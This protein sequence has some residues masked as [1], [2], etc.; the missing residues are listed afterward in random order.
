[1]QPSSLSD[2]KVLQLSDLPDTVWRAVFEGKA[3]LFLGAGFS[4]KTSSVTGEIL[5]TATDLAIKLG[6][7]A[8][9]SKDA[10]KR[11]DLKKIGTHVAKRH[12]DEMLE[13]LL[14]T[15][16]VYETGQVQ[17]EIVNQ[18]WQR[19]YTTNYDNV[20]EMA[21]AEEQK[22]IIPIVFSDDMTQ[23]K[24][25]LCIHIN[26]SVKNLNAATLQS[27]FK[28]ITKSYLDEK[29]YQSPWYPFMMEDFRVAS[30]IIVIGYSMN[31][32]DHIINRLF[33]ALGMRE[34]LLF[35]QPAGLDAVDIDDFTNYGDLV[36]C[37]VEGFS[38]FLKERKETYQPPV[39]VHRREDFICFDHSYREVS[40]QASLSY[41]DYVHFYFHGK[42]KPAFFQKR[43]TGEYEALASRHQLAEVLRN[44][45]R[46][47]IF[48]LTASLG[49][50]KTIF[51]EMLRHE[52]MET[53][54]HV[55]FF[56]AKHDGVEDEV[57]EIC[58]AYAKKSCFVVMDDVY[59]NLD[60]LEMFK[61]YDT[62][63]I[64]FVLT[65]RTALASRV[66]DGV[67][68][69]LEST[70]QI[71]TISLQ[72]LSANECYEMAA[73]LQSQNL[74]S[75]RYEMTHWT[76]GKLA[77]YFKTK[78][79][80]SIEQILLDVFE[81]SV[82]KEHME[83]LVRGSAEEDPDFRDLLIGL[84][85]ASVWDLG[86]D[87]TMIFVL[88]KFERTQAFGEKEQEVLS[89]LFV[90]QNMDAY[91]P[92]SSIFAKAVLFKIFRPQEIMQTM[93]RV[94]RELHVFGHTDATCESAMKAILSHGSYK[95]LISSAEGRVAVNQFYDSLRELSWYQENPFYW[96][97]FALSYMD[98]KEYETAEMCLDV[99]ETKAKA[100]PKFQ[101][102]QIMTVRADC[103]LSRLL[104]EADYAE[105]HS[106]IDVIQE[107]VEFLLRYVDHPL[108]D[109]SYIFT[110][111]RKC[112]AVYNRYRLTFG[113]TDRK[114]YI[115]Y[116]SNI[117]HRLRGWLDVA[118][119]NCS[120]IE[121]VQEIET[122]IKKAGTARTRKVK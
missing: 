11:H 18:P 25:D 39:S 12:R 67:C 31:S 65:T 7:L 96:E 30:K 35:V 82:A 58:T 104:D 105:M 32:N 19:I 119:S 103:R 5:G 108:N 43:T 20:V 86:L 52:L 9:L 92:V 62:R 45:E 94:A 8:G 42:W 1:M 37:G 91:R 99:A 89:E 49:N 110:V 64:T 120:M 93:G 102:F 21:A 115:S 56:R 81:K 117:A 113:G 98:Q 22:N 69:A 88:L 13:L 76:A 46:G 63:H 84:L 38:T 57:R 60:V 14:R 78:D 28:L 61:L 72:T 87:S 10:S 71:H 80:A 26:G 106:P 40:E 33:G 27:E 75:D 95:K 2:G 47:K 101:P 6:E 116:M 100:I 44:R 23:Q 55:F 66:C 73:A 107:A 54:T 122:S 74:L 77:D 50:G 85:A 70:Q 112:V 90:G 83:N 17:C 16:T 4:L 3:I 36:M 51:C 59:R 97:E 41:K 109:K 68:R 53:D 121:T 15:F 24:D 48:L 118:W 29:I 79:H 114:R 34:K 111:S